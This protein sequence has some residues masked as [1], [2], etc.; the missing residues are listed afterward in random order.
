MTPNNSAKCFHGK[1]SNRCFIPHA[2]HLD[3][4]WLHYMSDWATDPD[5]LMGFQKS[6]GKKKK[7]NTV[8]NTALTDVCY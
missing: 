6:V 3:G 5:S 7:K 1:A 2:V 4:V 8:F